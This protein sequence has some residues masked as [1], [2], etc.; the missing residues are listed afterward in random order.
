MPNT[1]EADG[2]CERLLALGASALSDA[3]LLAVIL[4]TGS[5]QGSALQLATRILAD[6]DG[7][8]GLAQASFLETTHA[9][10]VGSEKTAQI[11]AAVEIGRRLTILSPNHRPIIQHADD[12][13]SL[14]ADMHSLRQEQVR[15]L[16]LDSAQRLV[17]MQTVYVG[18]LNA[19]I[20]RISELFGKRLFVTVRQ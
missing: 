9:K 13:A 2:P 17:T 1:S 10:G 19:S 6:F 14:V 8:H 15:I 12:V 4:G 3:E 7:L 16:L 18:T 20:I 5:S 11:A